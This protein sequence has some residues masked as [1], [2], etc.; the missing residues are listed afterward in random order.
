MNTK[1]DMDM[2]CVFG[3]GGWEAPIFYL[4]TGSSNKGPHILSESKVQLG[5]YLD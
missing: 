3:G 5:R 1:E 2:V 4:I